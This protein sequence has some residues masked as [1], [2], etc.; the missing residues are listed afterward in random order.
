MDAAG[1]R[2]TGSGVQQLP[3]C[4]ELVREV[5][6][7]SRAAG[8]LTW[9]NRCRHS[10]QQRVT[11]SRRCRSGSLLGAVIPPTEKRKVGSSP[12]PL[13]TSYR[14][15][16]SALTSANVYCV[17]WCLQTSSDHDCPCVTVVGRSLSHADRTWSSRWSCAHPRRARHPGRLQLVP[18]RAGPVRQRRPSAVR[19]AMGRLRAPRKRVAGP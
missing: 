3:A 19:R 14:R 6:P 4:G 13:T 12:P 7:A 16:S 15:A 1:G 18:G 10:R 11:T 17:L 9:Q 2:A 5:P 8:S